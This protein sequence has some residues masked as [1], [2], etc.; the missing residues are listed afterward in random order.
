[1]EN[2]RSY[3][4]DNLTR[5]QRSRTMT[6]VKRK[7]TRA[8]IALRKALRARGLNGYR[9]DWK[10]APGRPDVAVTKQRL[11]V[12]VDGGYWHGRADRL[13]PGR[14]SYWDKKIAKNTEW[15]RRN[16]TLLRDSEWKVLRVWGDEAVRD[17]E[18][19][20][21]CALRRLT[22]TLTAEFLPHNHSS[23]GPTY[24]AQ[25]R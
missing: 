10:G 17:R 18:E 13:R 21:R 12:F 1:M 19:A 11:A 24:Q 2:A 22:A 5:E 23:N 8:E 20:A 6:A 9:V 4:G 25:C 7:D 3:N 14:S 16:E 15:G